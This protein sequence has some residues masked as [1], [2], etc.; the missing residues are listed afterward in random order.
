MWESLEKEFKSIY[1][2]I[3]DARSGAGADDVTMNFPHFKDLLFLASTNEHRPA[4]SSF[5]RQNRHVEKETSI[6]NKIPGEF[7][8]KKR[9]RQ[10]RQKKVPVL[11]NF[12]RVKIV[13]ATEMREVVKSAQDMLDQTCNTVLTSMNSCHSVAAEAKDPN[14]DFV[15][16]KLSFVPEDKLEEILRKILEGLEK[17]RKSE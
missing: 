9:A 11:D 12:A 16:E 1:I 7:S 14:F 5:G 2:K 3:K 6:W 10:S 15:Y 13:Q 4:M 17:V 8:G